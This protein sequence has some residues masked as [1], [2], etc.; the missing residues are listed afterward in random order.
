MSDLISI[1]DL[2]SILDVKS[3]QSIKRYAEK[4]GIRVHPLKAPPEL[5]FRKHVDAIHQHDVPRLVDHF[6]HGFV[7]TTKVSI[8][9]DG[10]VPISVLAREFSRA[11]MSVRHWIRKNNIVV[12]LKKQQGFNRKTKHISKTDADQFRTY[13]KSFNSPSDGR[14][15]KQITKEFQCAERAVKEFMDANPN[16]CGKIDMG[17]VKPRIVL[18]EYLQDFE[19]YLV[20]NYR[21][22][23]DNNE[24]VFFY[25]IALNEGNLIKTGCTWNPI[26]RCKHFATAVPHATVIGQWPCRRK[27]E[28][29]MR[30]FVM[31]GMVPSLSS[32]WISGREVFVVDNPELACQRAEEFSSQ[33][34]HPMP[35]VPNLDETSSFVGVLRQRDH[36]N[37]EWM[38]RLDIAGRRMTVASGFET[39]EEAAVQYDYHVRK[40]NPGAEFIT[41]IPNA[42]NQRMINFPEYDFS[43]FVPQ[44]QFNYTTGMEI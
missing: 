43:G 12:Q 14:T 5:K 34:G 10:A 18:N 35:D 37:I 30:Q 36:K 24:L 2:L 16:K 21:S 25:L 19:N 7:S 15:Q 26:E 33:M 40:A 4:I 44:R 23:R 39:E 1:L 13:R 41:R 31:Q 38:A 42:Q 32:G 9:D 6:V 3:T 11:D 27:E 20:K 17:C 22:K 29:Q 28:E 8:I